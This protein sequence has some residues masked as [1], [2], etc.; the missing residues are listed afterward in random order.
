MGQ[1]RPVT[2]RDYMC[3]K[4]VDE[5]KRALLAV[6]TDRQMRLMTAAQF[7]DLS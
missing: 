2:I 4:T 3:P 1:T 6:K 5:R 7:L